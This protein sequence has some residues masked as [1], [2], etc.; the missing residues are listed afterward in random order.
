MAFKTLFYIKRT[1]LLKNGDAPIYLKLTHNGSNT[2]FAINRSVDPILWNSAK[3]QVNGNTSIARQLNQFMKN[4]E[5]ELYEHLRL[6]KDQNAT[7]TCKSIRDSYLG[8]LD[9]KK[10]LVS[11]FEEHNRDIKKLINIDISSETYSK[12]IT[13]LKYIKEFIIKQYHED[14]LDIDIV[15]FSFLSQFESFL[16]V[17]KNLSHNSAMKYLSR[18]RKVIRI[19]HANRWIQFNPFTSFKLTYKKVDR[20]FL[21]NEEL[22]KLNET[23]LHHKRLEQ[24]R[25]CFLFSCYTG[26]AHSDLKSLSLSDIVIGNDSNE[27]IRINRKKT[28]ILSSIPLLDVTKELIIKYRENDYCQATNLILPVLSNQKMN[29]Y[30]KEIAVL[31]KI[32]KNLTSHLARHT[33]ATT[34]TLNNDVPIETVSKMLGHSSIE[35]TKIYARLLDKKVGNDMSKL[36]GIYS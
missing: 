13:G 35:M 16:K 20:G 24:V 10:T 29:A 17:K 32:D 18:L 21:T 1:K 26:L 28:G 23:K 12:Y 22:R 34:V 31:C 7:I 30:L 5:F 4:V 19:A 11:I 6:L 8:I 2:E 27:W 14:D 9:N 33:F 3:S 25:D 36:N 15:N